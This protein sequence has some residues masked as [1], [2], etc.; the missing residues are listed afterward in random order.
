MV[1]WAVE[2]SQF[3]V[4]Y[5]P[6]TAIKAQALVDIVAEFT[7]AEQDPKSDYWTMHIDGSV[8]SGMG[9]V[10]VIL[11]SPEKDILKYGVQLQFPTWQIMK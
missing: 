4:D 5:R 6:R 1:Q 8:A 7:I 2:L 3:D 9:G 11:S 10:G